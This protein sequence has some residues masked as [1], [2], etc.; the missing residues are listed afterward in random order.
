MKVY[1]PMQP[2][3]AREVHRRRRYLLEIF[4]HAP[5]HGGKR[6]R[7][8]LLADDMVHDAGEQVAIVHL[9]VH[10]PNRIYW[11]AR[12]NLVSL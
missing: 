2:L 8:D 10:V 1:Q 6:C 9:A 11:V 3:D 7:S 12:A 4:L 5:P